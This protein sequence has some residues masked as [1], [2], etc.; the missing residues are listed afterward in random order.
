M[1]FIN[2]KTDFEIANESNLSR[3]KLDELEKR[4]MFIHDQRNAIRKALRQGK[5]EGLR[6]GEEKGILNSVFLKG[7]GISTITG[8]PKVFSLYK[9][10][11]VYDDFLIENCGNGR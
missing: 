6:E 10:L 1:H 11:F 8:I 3:E 2:P 5:E 7:A 9:E 4:E